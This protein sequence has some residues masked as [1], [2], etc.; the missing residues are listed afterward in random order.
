MLDFLF[1]HIGNIM[2]YPNRLQTYGAALFS[3]LV[4]SSCGGGSSGGGNNIAS[5]AQNYSITYNTSSLSF[6]YLEG[7]SVAPQFVTAKDHGD[8]PASGVFVGATIEGTGIQQPVKITIDKNAGTASAQ[9]QPMEGLLTGTY[10]GTINFLACRDEKCSM[11]FSG[12]PHLVRYTIVVHPHL[13]AT[14]TALNYIIP[15]QQAG[16]A[17]TLLVTLPDDSSSTTPSVSY[18]AGASGWLQIQNNGS[19]LLLTPN[20]STLT[21]GI[22]TA[23]VQLQTNTSSPQTFSVPVKLTVVNDPLAHLIVDRNS[24]DFTGPE[25]Q[26]LPTQSL[27]LNVPIGTTASTEVNYATGNGWLQIKN[28]GANLVLTAS[29]KGLAAGHYNATLKVNAGTESV[30][31]PITL[32]VAYDALQHLFANSNSIAFTGVESQKISGQTLQLNVPDGGFASTNVSYG[33]GSNG[34][35]QVKN[36]GNNLV[37]T[38]LTAGL[39]YGSY[40][41]D[42]RIIHGNESI[43][44]PVNFVVNKGLVT[45]TSETGIITSDHLGT[46]MFTVMAVNGVSTPQWSATSDQPWL[47]LDSTSGAIGSDL[48]WHLDKNLF[49]AFTNNSNHTATITISGANL[50]TVKKLI[51]L[52]KQFTEIEH[53]DTLALLAGESGDVLLYGN[54]F[55][56]LSNFTGRLQLG[57]GLT[58]Q[59]ATVM[60]DKLARVTLQNVQAGS[61]AISLTTALGSPTHV[62]TLQVLERQS[63]NYQAISTSGKTKTSLV[64]DPVSKSA[65]TVD[66]TSSLIHRILWN[67]STFVD[68][69]K[70]VSNPLQLAMDRDQISVVLITSTGLLKR[71]DPLTLTQTSNTDTKIISGYS[72]TIW[73]PLVIDGSN[74]FWT[75]TISYDLDHNILKSYIND[76]FGRTAFGSSNGRRQIFSSD[77]Y[78][79]PLQSALL[80]DQLDDQFSIAPSDQAT[81]LFYDAASNRTGQYWALSNYALYDSSFLR[82]GKFSIPS[83]WI[84]NWTMLSRDGKRAYILAYRE[85]SISLDSNNPSIESTTSDM[86]RI[87]VFDTNVAQTQFPLMGYFDLKDYAGCRTFYNDNCSFRMAMTLSEDDRTLFFVG[88]KKFIVAPIPANFLPTTDPLSTTAT[89]TAR[90]RAMSTLALPSMIYAP[91]EM[92]LWLQK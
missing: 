80:H 3:A 17:Q 38:A 70:S 50:T 52:T 66:S 16:T 48:K 12:S 46:G 47:I 79:S 11:Q 54:G 4:L 69:V 22:Y 67:G 73:T 89:A 83:D 71:Y 9:I 53:I 29:T 30:F 75:N 92:K 55:A 26:I 36:N 18:G 31:I 63:F 62:N 37:I 35:L 40:T 6:D 86:P 1:N 15:E 58:L 81:N 68:T 32:T 57:S 8:Q 5:P 33:A 87:F 90:A 74:R 10:S 27:N 64:W 44:I 2:H 21:A 77:G 20:V 23:T 41:A 78:A 60:S 56:S 84:A 19:K 59:N 43:S 61:Y 49:G 28:I 34:W 85:G 72:S 65:F 13:S 91:K 88:A 24:V 14:P 39:T 45:P 7:S 82:L 42:L 25:A 76:S 51:T